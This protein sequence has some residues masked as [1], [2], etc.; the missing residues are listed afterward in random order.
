MSLGVPVKPTGWI[1]TYSCRILLV[2][3]FDQSFS[4]LD[5][6]KARC[7]M[8]VLA[9]ALLAPLG[10]LAQYGPDPDGVPA[11]FLCGWR[12]LAL[13]YATSLRPDSAAVVHD[14]LQMSHFCNGTDAAAAA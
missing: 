7:L 3:V 13:A 11:D 6:L 9:V 14:A 1:N 10:A 4:E 5:T 12:K 2:P 8:K